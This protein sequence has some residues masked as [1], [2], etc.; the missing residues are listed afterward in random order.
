MTLS[1]RTLVAGVTGE[2]IRHSLSPVIHN[3]WLKAAGI[4]GAYL[5]YPAKNEAAFDALV[6]AGRG[7]AFAGLNVTA[8][9]KGRAAAM[10]DEADATVRATGSANLLVFEYGRVHAFSTDGTGV[11]AALGE[12]A[13]DL[14]LKGAEVLMLGA[15]GAARAVVPALLD[16]GAARIVVRNRTAANAE[17][18]AA[19]FDGR[20]VA[21]T[22]GDGADARLVINAVVG[23][24]GH[25]FSETPGA[26][27]ALDMTYRPLKT[28]FLTA[29]ERAGVAPVDGLAMLI[30][31]ARPSFERLFGQAAPD[32]DIRSVVLKA[33]EDAA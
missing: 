25:D 24:P 8:P 15:G 23:D 10:A 1:A 30:G 13:P 4:D 33:L 14:D 28:P 17:A 9:W 6:A 12:Q 29:A 18:L 31:Q 22:A 3:A 32:I 16:A 19:A 21:E 11:I 20:V 5:A 27:A 2:P 26:S 7:G